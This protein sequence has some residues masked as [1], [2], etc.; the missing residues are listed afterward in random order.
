MLSRIFLILLGAVISTGALLFWLSLNALV[1]EGLPSD[2]EFSVDW[3]G[4]DAF[5]YFWLPFLAGAAIAV[6]A[7]LPRKKP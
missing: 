4:E 1:R 3:L 7:G 5:W 2:A 6:M